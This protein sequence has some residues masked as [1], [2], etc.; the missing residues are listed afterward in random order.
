[1]GG[2]VLGAFG[3]AF[4]GFGAGG[5][6]CVLAVGEKTL[7]GE[8]EDGGHG[9]SLFWGKL[10]WRWQSFPPG[11]RYRLGAVLHLGESITGA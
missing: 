6:L 2:G 7:V 8:G 9:T 5:F 11:R 10:F 4:C 1:M 3:F